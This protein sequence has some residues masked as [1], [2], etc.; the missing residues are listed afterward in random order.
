MHDCIVVGVA[1]SRPNVGH[2]SLAAVVAAAHSSPETAIQR[3]LLLRYSSLVDAIEG[4]LSVLLHLIGAIHLLQLDL[5]LLAKLGM[6]YQVG[7]D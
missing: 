6:V 5:R 1:S 4:R 2:G 7:L 3:L